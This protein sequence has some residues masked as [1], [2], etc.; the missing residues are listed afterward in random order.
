MAIRVQADNGLQQRAGQL[1]DERNEPNL[2][3]IELEVLLEDW[4]DGRNQ[5][6]HHVVEQ[7]TE[8]EGR[9][10]FEGGIH[11]PVQSHEWSFDR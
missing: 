2:C 11:Y 9:E 5:R 8:A 6:L 7:M 3:E 1:Q 4:I 10:D